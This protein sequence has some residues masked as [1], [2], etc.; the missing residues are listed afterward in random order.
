MSFAALQRQRVTRE[1]ILRNPC[2]LWVDTF[3]TSWALAMPS[4]FDTSTAP[5]N[6]LS[7]RPRG[8]PICNHRPAL[9]RRARTRSLWLH[10]GRCKPTAFTIR[11]D[12]RTRT[13]VGG[14]VRFGVEPPS[15][16]A[17]QRAQYDAAPRPTRKGERN[18]R[19]VNVHDGRGP[20]R[21]GDGAQRRAGFCGP[22]Q[23]RRTS[24]WVV[25]IAHRAS[26]TLARS[27]RSVVLRAQRRLAPWRLIPNGLGRFRATPMPGVA[28]LSAPRGEL[29]R[30]SPL[31]IGPSGSSASHEAF[32]KPIGP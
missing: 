13:S 25:N 26:T 23:N 7:S 8:V 1:A 6:A 20:G 31:R 12:P 17:S 15:R 21:L 9:H 5:Y 16:Q 2:D 32:G 30:N 18:N 29:A 27:W 3:G 11:G 4:N 24:G 10:A 28:A 14:V 19:S 22:S